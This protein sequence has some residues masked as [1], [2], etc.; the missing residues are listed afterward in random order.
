MKLRD[1]IGLAIA[2]VLAI[3]V[4]FLTRVFLNRESKSDSPVQVQQVELNRILVAKNDL[5]LGDKI[6]AGDLT[7][8]DWP[9][10]AIN[11]SY[12]KEGTVKIESFVGAI[13]RERLDKGEPV[14]SSI[15]VRPGE[16]GL[17]AALVGSG[18]R[19]VSID[20]TPQS[21]SSGLIFPGDYV[22]VILSKSVSPASG[23]QYGKSR[24]IISNVKVLAIDVQM[25]DT[26]EKPK[27]PPRV[28]TLELTPAQAE[29]ITASVKE[30]TLSLSLYSIEKSTSEPQSTEE[31][32]VKQG[33]ILLMRGK[34]KNEIQVQEH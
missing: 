13:V 23:A 34:E 18:K 17:L 26:H 5:Y 3:G 28:A 27:D 15:L 2:L 25:A 31:N 14:T 4:A 12:V 32:L 22:D 11:A 6:K 21:A 30:G 33:T 9:Q 19:A 1:I 10:N 16:Q 29:L 20:V 8:Q 7:W 24:T